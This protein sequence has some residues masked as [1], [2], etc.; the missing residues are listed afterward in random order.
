MKYILIILFYILLTASIFCDWFIEDI[1]DSG[2]MLILAGIAT[3]LAIK[4]EE[5]P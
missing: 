2:D 1:L 5:K 3:I 4:L